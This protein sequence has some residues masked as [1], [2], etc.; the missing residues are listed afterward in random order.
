MKKLGLALG[1][2]GAKGL[3][4]IP[5][6][7]VLDE[8]GLRPHRI[9]GTSIGAVIGAL[10][11]SGLSGARIREG[12]RKMVITRGDSFREALR[13]KD[14]L[15]WIQ[16]MDL[17][18][19]RHGLF[20]GD[21]FIGFLYDAMRARTFEEL[22]IPL[23]VVA[24][25]F[26]TSEQV[27]LDSGDLLDAIKASMG[28]PGVFTPVTRGGRVLIDGGGVNPVPYDVLDD[29]DFVVAIDV[30]GDLRRDAPRVPNLFRAVLGTFDIMQKSIIVEKLKHVSPDIYI[31]PAITGVDILEFYKADEIYEMAKPAVRKLKQALEKVL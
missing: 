9:A 6:L 12:V 13:K 11:A 25:D 1:G 27:I 8:L 20:K 3:A 5:M 26:N 31:R 24:T 4:H 21:K 2:G 17:E 23:R 16:F 30:M 22:Q 19:G 14:A 15:K 7:E 18:F 28:L 10:Y 29:C